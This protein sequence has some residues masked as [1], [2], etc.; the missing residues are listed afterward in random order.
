[1][2]IWHTFNILAYQD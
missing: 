2:N 1:M